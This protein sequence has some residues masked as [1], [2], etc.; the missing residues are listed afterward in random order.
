MSLFL[1]VQRANPPYTPENV[2]P[3][4]LAS[5]RMVLIQ[6]LY[7]VAVMEACRELLG[8][9]HGGRVR[10]KWPNDIY[11]VPS[12]QQGD[13]TE[14]KKIGGILVST[15]FAGDSVDVIIGSSALQ[16]PPLH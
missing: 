15:N 8:E 5:P 12:G 13:I 10:L 3:G 1:R 7:G 6:Y 11:A 2:Q 16:G 9:E 4:R 14:M